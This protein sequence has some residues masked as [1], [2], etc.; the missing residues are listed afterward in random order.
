MV[1]AAGRVTDD[2]IQRVFLNEFAIKA[3]FVVDVDHGP[4]LWVGGVRA[5]FVQG[6]FEFEPSSHKTGSAAAGQVV[7]L[8]HEYFVPGFG[9][10]GRSGETSVPGADNDHIIFLH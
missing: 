4:H 10:G 9:T 8:E 3:Q 7:F 2:A 6:R 1:V 5:Q